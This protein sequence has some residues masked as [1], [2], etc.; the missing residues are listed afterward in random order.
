MRDSYFD[1][2]TATLQQMVDQM[3]DKSSLLAA[4]RAKFYHGA[5]KLE[6]MEAQSKPPSTE[7]RRRVEFIIAQDIIKLVKEWR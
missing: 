7:Q 4:V 2:K 1:P 5:A 3:Q 6:Q